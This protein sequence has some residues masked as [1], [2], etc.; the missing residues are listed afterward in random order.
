[1]IAEP[2]SAAALDAFLLP[3]LAALDAALAAEA[4]ANTRKIIVLD[5]DPTGV[6]TVHDVSVYTDWSKERLRRGFAAPE[7]LFL[8]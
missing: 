8:C 3:D 4:Q 2:R 7:K 6:Q 5:D 1:M